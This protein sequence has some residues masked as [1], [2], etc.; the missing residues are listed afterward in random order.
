MT[1]PS[2]DSGPL[3]RCDDCG[4]FLPP[5]AAACPNCTASPSRLGS[6]LGKV[7]LQA[8]TG[9]AFAMTLMACYGAPYREPAVVERPPNSMCED[10][11]TDADSDGSCETNCADYAQSS[12][13]PP[14][15]EPTLTRASDDPVPDDPPPD[16]TPPPFPSDEE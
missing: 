1:A 14:G 11:W 15:C 9:S 6:R 10:G 8:A 3:Q 7:A 2:H 13:A 16:D 5:Q 12:A 4:G